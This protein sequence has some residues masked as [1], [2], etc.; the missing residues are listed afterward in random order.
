LGSLEEHQAPG[1]A[2]GS[3]CV[4]HV[5]EEIGAVV[6][7]A[8]ADELGRH[9]DIVRNVPNCL[10]LQKQPG[11]RGVSQRVRRD[12]GAKASSSA[13]RAPTSTSLFD[14]RTAVLDDK[15]SSLLPGSP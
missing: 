11:D 14:L 3:K 1:C 5:L 7:V 15:L 10:P 8:L 9:P 6:T 2:P 4:P 12:I 13:S